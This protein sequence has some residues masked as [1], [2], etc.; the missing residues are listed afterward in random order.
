MLSVLGER[1]LVFEKK[2]PQSNPLNHV[3]KKIAL[4]LVLTKKLFI[5]S[6]V[7]DDTSFYFDFHEHNYR[8]CWFKLLCSLMFKTFYST[9]RVKNS[10]NM[11][12]QPS[13]Y[14]IKGAVGNSYKRK[15]QAP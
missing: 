9:L 6:E 15:K 4:H 3:K 13:Y 12:L 8:H 1:I 10:A 5:V 14:V 7:A 2:N 11:Y